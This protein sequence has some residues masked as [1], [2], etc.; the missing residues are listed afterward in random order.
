[1]AAHYN[2]AVIPARPYTPRDKAKAETSVLIVERWIMTRLSK[3]RFYSLNALNN[4]LKELVTAMNQRPFQKKQGSRYS[5]F[6]KFEKDALRALP[7][8]RYE[9]AQFST[10]RVPSDYHIRID[11]NYYSVPYT[12]VGLKVFCRYTSTTIEV[13]HR[14]QRVASHMLSFEK[15]KKSTCTEHMPKAHQEYDQ[16]T[17]QTFLNWA[18]NTGSGVAHVAAEVVATKPHP[19]QCSKIHYGLKR[20]CKEFGKQRLNKACQRAL[21]VGCIQFKSI[22]SILKHKLDQTPYVNVASTN[23]TP[24]HANVRGADYYHK[25]C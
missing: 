12:L 19:E 22:E 8:S 24:K 18:K 4:A 16:W 15:D 20:L 25:L 13:L 17:P 9:F 23:T 6:I 21:A 14:H 11:G 2:T 3:Q 1:M 5:Q 10:Q 7:N